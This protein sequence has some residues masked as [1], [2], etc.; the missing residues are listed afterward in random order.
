M[1]KY[2][3][4]SRVIN[5]GRLINKYVTLLCY[6]YL[7]K[8]GEFLNPLRDNKEQINKVER[9]I[10]LHNFNAQFMQKPIISNLKYVSK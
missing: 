9:E 6:T 8:K 5:T 2:A 10:G 7:F 4:L 1:K 3:Y